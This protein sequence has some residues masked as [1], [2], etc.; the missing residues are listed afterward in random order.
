VQAGEGGADGEA[1]E[2]GLG[3]GRV[4]YALLAEAVEEALGDFV[5]RGC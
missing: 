1:C 3:D 2:A 5:A 4:D